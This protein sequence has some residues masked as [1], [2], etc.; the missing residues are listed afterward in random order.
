MTRKEIDAIWV[1]A[2][3]AELDLVTVMKI[4][5][6]TKSELAK[7]LK[8][9]N[10]KLDGIL[11]GE[12]PTKKLMFIILNRLFEAKR[13]G[14]RPRVMRVADRAIGGLENTDNVKTGFQGEQDKEVLSKKGDVK[15]MIMGSFEKK[16][17]KVAKEEMEKAI[18]EYKKGEVNTE[19]LGEY[20]PE[21]KASLKLIKEFTVFDAEKKETTA[22]K[23]CEL[24]VTVPTM[25][26]KRFMTISEDGELS[27]FSELETALAYARYILARGD[28]NENTN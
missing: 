18:K 4:N 17:I 6:W 3:M 19:V 14:I 10:G 16:E 25:D 8:M 12:M 2:A 23:V 24:I 27:L 21:E 28:E 15:K 1:K 9:A 13:Y 7:K 26:I 5:S 22:A 11:S 20:E